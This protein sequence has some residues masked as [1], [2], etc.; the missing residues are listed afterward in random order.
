MLSTVNIT[1]RTESTRSAFCANEV[2][3]RLA[4]WKTRACRIIDICV[5]VW[6]SNILITTD[7]ALLT[8]IIRLKMYLM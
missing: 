5:S 1:N 6:K 4:E 7:C 2:A 8:N 3:L